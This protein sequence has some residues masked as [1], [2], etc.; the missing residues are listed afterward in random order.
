VTKLGL[1][2]IAAT[3]AGCASTR[4]EKAAAFQRDLPQ[5]VAAC[6]GWIEVDPRLDG[7][8][9]RSDGFKACRQLS[10]N[11][12]LT[13]VHPAIASAYVRSVSHNGASSIQNSGA[14]A[15]YAVPMPL[16]QVQ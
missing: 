6:N 3:L 8:T 10:V 7:P 1:L 14:S 5:L 12:S 4:Q 11:K 13:L 16:P 15:T 2:I 9:I